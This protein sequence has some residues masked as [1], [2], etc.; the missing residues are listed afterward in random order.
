MKTVNLAISISHC[1]CC[2]ICYSNNTFLMQNKITPAL[3]NS[4]FKCITLQNTK[5]KQTL[6]S[7]L[8][9]QKFK[10]SL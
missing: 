3:S 7:M 1:E 4:H 2:E 5:S 8:F 6:N 10:F 9:I